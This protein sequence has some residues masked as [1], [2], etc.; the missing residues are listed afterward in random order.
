MFL[1]PSGAECAHLDSTM[2]ERDWADLASKLRAKAADKATGPEETKLLLDKA[3]EFEKR[4]KKNQPFEQ[5]T[6]EEFVSKYFVAFEQ[7]ADSFI[8]NS[9]PDLEDI[10]EYGYHHN[11]EGDE[12]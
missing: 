8:K 12:W 9:W 5:M 2:P 7:E 3:E 11:R 6:R 4:A 10:I 1:K